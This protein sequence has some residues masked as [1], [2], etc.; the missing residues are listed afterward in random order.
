MLG[1]GQA[2]RLPDALVQALRTNRA[3]GLYCMPTLQNPTTTVMS[4]GRR[5]KIAAI[6]AEHDLPIIEDDVYGFLLER[7]ATPLAALRP[8]G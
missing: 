2:P 3:R 6:C 8:Q 5:R 1:I 4:E 7:Q